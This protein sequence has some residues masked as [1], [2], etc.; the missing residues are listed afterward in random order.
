MGSLSTIAYGALLF[1]RWTG[2]IGLGIFAMAVLFSESIRSR[3]SPGRIMQ[4]VASS[5]LAMVLFWTLPTLMNYARTDSRIVVPN[6]PIGSY[7]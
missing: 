5:L 7:R 2:S 1:F 4:V 6:A 3:M